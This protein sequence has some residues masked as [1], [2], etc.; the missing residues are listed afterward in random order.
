MTDETIENFTVG[1]WLN[2]AA[3][4]TTDGEGIILA[5][6]SFTG[7]SGS[8]GFQIKSIRASGLYSFAFTVGD[9]IS[10]ATVQTTPLSKTGFESLYLNKFVQICA[11]FAANTSKIYVNSLLLNTQTHALES[12][13]QSNDGITTLMG[14]AGANSFLAGNKIEDIFVYNRTMTNGDVTELYLHQKSRKKHLNN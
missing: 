2:M 4:R 8:K 9:G 1:A 12:F 11:T 13:E 7:L 3:T 14:R 6:D 5:T 10:V